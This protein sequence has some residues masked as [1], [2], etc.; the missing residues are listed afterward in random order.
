[1]PKISFEI[2][3]E[4]RD[5][6]AALQRMQKEITKLEE[7]N[8]RLVNQSKEAAKQAKESAKSQSD[9]L[10]GVVTKAASLAAGYLSASTALRLLN[11]E[12]ERQNRL[13]D[14]NARRVTGLAG[15]ERGYLSNLG[16][17]AAE[18]SA[19][20][21]QLQQ[22]A[23]TRGV[24]LDQAYRSA[25]QALGF[26]QGGVGSQA[27]AAFDVAARFNPYDTEQLTYGLLAAQRL[28]GSSDP[29]S[30]LGFIKS[31][32]DYSPIANTGQLAQNLIPGATG[33]KL[34]NK[35]QVSDAE[36]A[37]LVNALSDVRVDVTGE[38]SARTAQ[39]LAAAGKRAFPNLN[40]DQLI[41]YAQNNPAA[42][43]KVADLIEEGGTKAAAVSLLS[44]ANSDAAKAYRASKAGIAASGQ[45]VARAESAI[46]ANEATP[47]QAVG[48]LDRGLAAG[49]EALG[50]GNTASAQAGVV[51]NRLDELSLQAGESWIA[52]A[53][54]S[55]AANVSSF[56]SG[57]PLAE[58]LNRA[59]HL[60]DYATPGTPAASEL[61]AVVEAIG[62][63]R[64]DLGQAL[65]QNATNDLNTHTEG[66]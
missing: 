58:Q 60:R 55:M 62:R 64:T 12:T 34:I 7:A 61:N 27:N 31:V 21:A 42:A 32:Q 15:A 44:D 16:G 26:T 23:R 39:R 9:M 37:S 36:A 59:V 63:L 11:N 4:D 66:R 51:R 13:Q 24:P 40:T 20:I 48:A 8:K 14:E 3:G 50:V 52:S 33:V 5:L 38:E 56:F 57:D 30:N 6:S 65:R 18:R 47:T 25:G 10:E 2:T 54:N 45:R 17:S 19:A 1:M 53:Y 35:G 43:K 29:M 46:R 49:V 22:T 28:T 41:A